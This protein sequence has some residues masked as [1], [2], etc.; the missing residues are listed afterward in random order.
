[1]LIADPDELLLAGYREVLL[2][3]DLEVVTALSGLECIARLSER[4]PDVLVLEPLLPW[5]GGEGVLSIMSNSSELAVVPVILLTS[6]RDSRVLD[7][8]ARFP[9]SDYCVKPITPQRLTCRVRTVLDVRRPLNVLAEQ[10]HRLE[11]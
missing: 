2:A 11:T 10:K 3:N 6:C 7:G 5:G 8:V 9:I 1:V 4:V